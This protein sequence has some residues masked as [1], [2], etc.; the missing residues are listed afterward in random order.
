MG[1]NTTF[2]YSNLDE[3]IYTEQSEGF[4]DTRRDRLVVN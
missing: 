1:V 4:S 3:Q 2:P